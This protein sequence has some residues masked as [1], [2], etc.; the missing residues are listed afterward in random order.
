[1][2]LPRLAFSS[3]RYHR[4]LHAGLA[5]GAFIACAVLTGSLLVG[6]AVDK[7]LQDIA[8]TRLGQVAF[9]LDWGTRYFDSGLAAAVKERLNVEAPPASRTVVAAVLSL[10]GVAENIPDTDRPVNRVNRAWVYGI[11]PEFGQ[12]APL[13]GSL[14]QPGPQEAFVNESMA[15]LLGLK[16][17][18]SLV[19]RIPKPSQI[20]TEAPLASGKERDTA[21]ARVS[22]RKVLADKNA[23][24]FSLA[25]E[26]AMPAN[27]FVNVDW[28]CELAGLPGKAN[29]LLANGDTSLDAL[30]D[31]LAAAWR[32]EL[33]G[34]QWHTHPSGALQ[35]ESERLFIEETLVNAALK[36]GN[37]RPLLTY[38]A[39]RIAGRDRSTPYSFVTAGAAPPDTPKG[40][41]CINRW[42][43]D[44]LD[45]ETGSTVSI[46]WYEPLPS[47]TFEEHTVDAPIHRILPMED[48]VVERD[49]APRFPGLSDVNSCQDWDIGMPLNEEQLKDPENEA[50][51]KEFGQTPKLLTTFDT[52]RT[53]W[54]NLYGTV[55]AIRFQDPAATPDA[56]SGKLVNLLDPEQLGLR[57][58]PVRQDALQAVAQAIDFGAL[59]TGM[60]TFLI[61]A[62]LLLLGLLYAHG[63]QARSSEVGTLLA[64]GWTLARTRAYLLLEAVPGCLVGATA[65]SFAG[66]AYARL[67]V[68]A[69]QRFWP[70][71]VAG[72]PVYYPDTPARI[73]L[74]GA[75]ITACCVF[76][77]VSLCVLRAGRRPV[78][79]LLQGDLT[80]PLASRSRADVLFLAALLMISPVTVFSFGM[81]LFDKQGDPTAWFFLSGVTTLAVLL[82]AYGLF[83]GRQRRLTSSHAS[84][85]G[86]LVSQLARRRGR[87]LGVAAVTGSGVFML[88]SVVSMQAAMNYAP[89]HRESGA[90]GFSVFA[91]TTLPVRAEGER[92]LGI[93][94]QKVVPLRVRE[95]DDAG[96]LNLNRARTP[97]ILGVAP[98]VLA[99]R[100]A[101]G[102][103]GETERLWALLDQPLSGDVFPALVGDA[104]TAMWGLQAQ[105]DPLSGTEYAYVDGTGR[106]FHIRT[107]G[108]LP[109][110]LS[111]FQGSLLISEQ[112]FMRLFP[113]EGGYRAFLIETTEAAEVAARLN[114]EYGRQGMEAIP[115]AERLRAFYAVERAYLA[116]FLVL[117]GLGLLLGAGGAAVITWRT[118]AERRPEFALL[119]AVGFE[120]A[121]IRRMTGIETASLVSAGLLIGA[122]AAGLA[123]TPLLLRNHSPLDWVSLSALV[124]ILLF[125]YL[126]M[127]LAVTMAFLRNLP[128]SALRKE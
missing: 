122:F 25:A 31:A 127:A 114:R 98:G 52:G 95:G 70:D 29:L 126:G 112:N 32:P 120:A 116:M 14:E 86:I 37:A 26:Q 101:F 117:G 94:R 9:A 18:D 119:T 44:T 11:G 99:N 121:T 89:E 76:V 103:P 62:A 97:R 108:K 43:A 6:H 30:S 56:L 88:L 125:V 96:C 46:S 23:G 49:L 93:E 80:A 24:R 39:N 3:I 115:S 58:S 47:G 77:V 100:K 50:Y 17:G 27:V 128:L 57:F 90:G 15:R 19:L 21:V 105:T 110:R 54:G 51:W 10:R 53:W 73:L 34:Y 123:T 79:S 33:L 69:L 74:Q 60:S 83:L 67:L 75:G 78:R 118:L 72:T 66:A 48:L 91:T 68:H 64:S 35:L 38:L 22:I 40:A 82:F 20:P 13:E 107:V 63:L 28:L 42:L 2:V 16:P 7:T 41:V 12:I 65:G 71:A 87:S 1:M 55:T 61:S 81:G 36:L 59:F 45:A 111:L 102:L 8:T 84:I 85:S 109:M 5:A 104:D 124:A 106:S 92:L 4:R 113:N